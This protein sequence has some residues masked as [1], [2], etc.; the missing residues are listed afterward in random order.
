M[1]RVAEARVSQVLRDAVGRLRAAGLATARQDAELL[2]AR[3]L[4]TTRLALH[5]E[6]GRL[7]EPEALVELEALLARRAAHEPLQY[8]LGAEE[9]AGMRLAVG[10]GVFVPRPETELLVERAVALCPDGPALVL[11][12]CTGSGAVAC[13]LAVRRP[14]AVVWAVELSPAAARWARANVEAVGVAGRVRVVEGDLFGPVEALAGCADLVVANPPYI[15]GTSWPDL[16][17]EVRDWEPPLALDGGPDGLA[18]IHRILADAPRFARP[19]GTVL[20]EIGHDHAGRL[21]PHLAADPRYDRPVF[22]RDLPGY[23]RVLEVRVRDG[24]GGLTP[25]APP[26]PATGRRPSDRWEGG[27]KAEG[28]RRIGGVAGGPE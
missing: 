3:V 17:G 26:S 19:D 7:V 21:R 18:L 11:D 10:P 14:R 5:L 16:P 13:A 4:A 25:Q 9:F 12:L 22:H 2:L 20:L 28:R 6:P 23:E 24:S 1:T 8:V 27:P 15:A